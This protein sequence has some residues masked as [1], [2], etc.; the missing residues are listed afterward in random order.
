MHDFYYMLTVKPSSHLELFSDFLVDLLPVGFEETDDGFIIRSEES[1]ETVSWGIEQFTEALQRATGEV[2]DVEMAMTKE[3]NDD[4]IAQYQQSITPVQI[5]PF[6]IHPTWE[7]PKEG[8]LNIAIDP[9]LAFGTGHHPTTASCLRAVAQYVKEG[10]EV[11]DVGCGSGILAMAAIL[12]GAV[13]DACDTDPLSVENALA[14]AEQNNLVY[15]RIWEG[16]VQES[17]DKYDVIIA[18]IVADVLVFIAS[19]LKKRLKEGGVVVL[20][21]IMDKYEDKVLRAYKT[22]DLTERIVENEWV[23]LVMTQKGNG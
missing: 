17:N 13:V 3:K 15:R 11:M 10:D 2:I 14:N 4:W 7:A 6:Y 22:F 23:T 19:D 20:S 18:N 9:A 12:K 5:D 16:P 8:M 21:G 1:L